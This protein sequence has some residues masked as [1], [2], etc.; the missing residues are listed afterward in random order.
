MLHNDGHIGLDNASVVGTQQNRFNNCK[1][2]EA[3]VQGT[4]RAHRPLVRSGRIAVVVEYRD[5]DMS[6]I[7]SCIQNAHSLAAVCNLRLLTS[8]SDQW[9]CSCRYITS[10]KCCSHPIDISRIVCCT[11]V[12]DCCRLCSAYLVPLA[13]TLL[14]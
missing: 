11:D 6:I 10:R 14:R 4:Q 7:V 1:I 9:D 12:T 2:V 3:H 8:A 5:L 13:S